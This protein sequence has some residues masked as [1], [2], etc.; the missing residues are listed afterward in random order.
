M[1]YTKNFKN[2]TIRKPTRDFPGGLVVK[3]LPSNAHDVG[4]I[5]GWG[6]KIPYAGKDKTMEIVKTSVIA[7]GW[8][9]GKMNRHSTVDF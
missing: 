5:P 2:S 9:E 6:T 1:K 8:G 4:S 3:Y 7:R